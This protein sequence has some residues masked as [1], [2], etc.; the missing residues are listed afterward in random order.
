[1]GMEAPEKTTSDLRLRR[2]KKAII[3]VK[4]NS[5]CKGPEVRMSSG[6]SQSRKVARMI[7][8]CDPGEWYRSRV[9]REL[10]PSSLRHCGPREEV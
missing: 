6:C 4:R 3:H 1:M 2:E 9:E 5:R 10:G 8:E 7:W